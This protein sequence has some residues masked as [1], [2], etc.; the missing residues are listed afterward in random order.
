MDDLHAAIAARIDEV[1]ASVRAYQRGLDVGAT[2]LIQHP[3]AILRGLAED[4][5]ILRRHANEGYPGFGPDL[6]GWCSE[7]T[8]SGQIRVRWPCAEVRSLARRHGIEVPDDP[9]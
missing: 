8:E 4:R 7:E 9:A 6:C 2:V 3:E 1:E 5:D